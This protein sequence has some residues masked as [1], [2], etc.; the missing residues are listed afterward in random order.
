[1]EVEKMVEDFVH[2]LFPYQSEGL[3][4]LLFVVIRVYLLWAR[5]NNMFLLQA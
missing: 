2:F 3:S 5:R 1:M 4:Q